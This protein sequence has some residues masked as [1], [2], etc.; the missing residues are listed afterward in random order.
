MRRQPVFVTHNAAKMIHPIAPLKAKARTEIYKIANGVC[1]ALGLES[2][3]V[4]LSNVTLLNIIRITKAKLA[5]MKIGT[6]ANAR[7][8]RTG[9]LSRSL[10]IGRPRSRSRLII[11]AIA[12]ASTMKAQTATTI[13]LVMSLPLGSI[14]AMIVS[15]PGWADQCSAARDRPGPTVII[16]PYNAETVD[17]AE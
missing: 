1:H 16:W 10:G 9:R 2:E 5:A 12:A 4:I 13:M 11:A 3:G 17:V 6:I 15:R 8:R 7:L 14:R